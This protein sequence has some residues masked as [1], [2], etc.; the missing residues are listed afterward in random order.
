VHGLFAE[1]FGDVGGALVRLR[2]TLTQALSDRV[3]VFGGP[4]LSL[5]LSDDFD[6]DGLAPFSVYD[7]ATGDGFVRLW[8][9][10][11]AGLRLRI[12]DG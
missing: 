1:D 12:T 8:P 3:A 5:F 11:E 9:G 4:A 2:A 6:G 7:D 10:L